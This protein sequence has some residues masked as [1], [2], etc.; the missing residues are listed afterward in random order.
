MRSLSQTSTTSSAALTKGV[1]RPR[2]GA[3]SWFWMLDG[4]VIDSGGVGR[5]ALVTA[6]HTIGDAWI[7]LE[8]NVSANCSLVLH[9]TPETTLHDALGAIEA[10][11]NARSGA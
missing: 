11:L 7:Q 8:C 4:R 10:V 5:T 1:P 9:V 3:D 2:H 6:I